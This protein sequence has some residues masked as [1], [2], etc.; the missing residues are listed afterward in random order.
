M[1]AYIIIKCIYKPGSTGF[2]V[3]PS[4]VINSPIIVLELGVNG[5]TYC[6][7]HTKH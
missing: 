1:I 3:Y 4:N 7:I 5:S 6:N 2:I